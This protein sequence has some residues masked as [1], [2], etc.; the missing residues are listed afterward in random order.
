[1]QRIKKCLTYGLAIASVAIANGVESRSALAIPRFERST[2]A[3]TR[4]FRANPT[5]PTQP[6]ARRINIYYP[7]ATCDRLVPETLTAPAE[8]ALET[9]VGQVIERSLN[10]DFDLVGYRVT[11]DNTT[12][13]IDLRLA[14]D[15]KRH[16]LSLSQCEKFAL[17]GSLRQTLTSNPDWNIETV[18]FTSQGEEIAF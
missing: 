11:V 10:G 6:I 17:F 16:F 13:I 5:Q 3:S 8:N 2:T 18:R 15:S 7:N 9:A 4:I 12:A 14:P 1:M